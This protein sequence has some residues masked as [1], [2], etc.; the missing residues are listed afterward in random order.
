MPSLKN[1]G[2]ELDGKMT[3]KNPEILGA[4]GTWLN[5]HPNATGKGA[6][7]ELQ[8]H[9]HTLFPDEVKSPQIISDQEEGKET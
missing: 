3:V 8:Q 4:I 9:L 7:D 5:G 6:Y 1:L 2:V